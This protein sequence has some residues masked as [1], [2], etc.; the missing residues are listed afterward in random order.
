MGGSTDVPRG[1]RAVLGRLRLD[2]QLIKNRFPTLS[3]QNLSCQ[4]LSQQTHRTKTGSKREDYGRITGGSREDHERITGGL[5]EDY[6]GPQQ[7]PSASIE[8]EPIQIRRSEP[9]ST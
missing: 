6:G 8:P 7:R 5:R 2:S 9:E 4:T 3:Y 1:S